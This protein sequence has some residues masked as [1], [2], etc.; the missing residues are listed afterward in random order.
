MNYTKGEWKVSSTAFD[1]AYQTFVVNEDLELISE[2]TGDSPEESIANANLIA[3]APNMYEAL[4]KARQHFGHMILT[5]E[6]AQVVTVIDEAL[7][8]AEGK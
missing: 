8:K 6:E 5:Y 1:R 3:A 4:R 2:A 7:A